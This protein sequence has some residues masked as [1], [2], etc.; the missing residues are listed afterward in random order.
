MYS[1]Q[2]WTW[3]FFYSSSDYIFSVMSSDR[4]NLD[5]LKLT[6]WNSFESLICCNL[7]KITKSLLI[8]ERFY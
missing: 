2:W 4:E 5:Y 1:I 3:L 8:L 7:L 6:F